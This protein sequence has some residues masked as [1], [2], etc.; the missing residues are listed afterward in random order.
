MTEPIVANAET[1]MEPDGG[2]DSTY[3]HSSMIG[4]DGVCLNASCSLPGDAADEDVAAALLRSAVAV[5]QMRSSGAW[6]ALQRLL[7]EPGGKP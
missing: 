5:A 3:V 7:A 6:M 2:D 4:V 1:T